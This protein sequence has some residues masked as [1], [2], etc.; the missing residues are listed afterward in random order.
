MENRDF[1]PLFG[2][3]REEI[4]LKRA[5]LA[6][7][8]A[9]ARFEPI[10][11][12]RSE[13]Y[14]ATFQDAIRLTYPKVRLQK[15]AP[16]PLGGDPEAF[17]SFESDSWRVSLTTTFISLET[18][19]YSSRTDF[20]ARFKD[21]VSALKVT[22][23]SARVTRVGVRYV[24]QITMPEVDDITKLLRSEMLGVAHSSLAPWLRHSVS[25][26]FCEVAEGNLLARWGL[27]PPHGSHDPNVMIA[28]P[29]K[30]WFL[31]FDVYRQYEEPFEEMNAEAIHK[32]AYSLA[33][34]A[35]ALFS[36]ATTDDFAKTYG[37]AE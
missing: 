16:F 25:E 13:D 18:A 26:M 27:L 15:V 6:R 5:P 21:I 32:M 24:D 10:F 2:E 23:N 36:W 20:M 8:I 35:Y 14:V 30:S 34:R 37:G 17:W 28:G 3:P 31:D 33:T 9:Q 11:R 19:A 29:N 7:V 1:D 22:V 12:I 4:P